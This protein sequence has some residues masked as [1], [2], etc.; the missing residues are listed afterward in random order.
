MCV[1]S[2][3]LWQSMVSNNVGWWVGEGVYWADLYNGEKRGEG[4]RKSMWVQQACECGDQESET[5][6][7]LLWWWS[8]MPHS[9]RQ[10]L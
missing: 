3:G 2:F 8:H 5:A 7:R 4:G 9:C 10:A 1:F 6:L